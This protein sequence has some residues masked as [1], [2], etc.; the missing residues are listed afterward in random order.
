MVSVYL[1]GIEASVTVDNQ[2]VAVDTLLC[3]LALKERGNI[4]IEKFQE[5]FISGLFIRIA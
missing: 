4:S 3:D 2:D 5:Q 1:H